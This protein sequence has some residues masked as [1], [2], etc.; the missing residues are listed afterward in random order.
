MNRM[1]KLTALILLICFARVTW[2]NILPPT[3]Q[4]IAVSTTYDR[5]GAIAKLSIWD[6]TSGGYDT[7][8]KSKWGLNFWT[9]NSET[10][11][12]HGMCPTRVAHNGEWNMVIS[13]KFVEQR[14]GASQVIKLSATRRSEWV[15]ADY[16]GSEGG[17]YGDE[18]PMNA[19]GQ[20]ICGSTYT[21]GVAL[22]IHIAPDELKKI[23]VGG[24]WKAR[25]NITLHSNHD[26]TKYNWQADITLNV[27]DN[28]NQAI[29][30]PEFGEA[31]PQIDLNLRP[32]PGTQVN[33]SKLRG[34][35][36][37][38]MCLYDGYGGN[39]SSFVLNFQDTGAA[40]GRDSALFSV[41][42]EGGDAQ[43][44]QDRIDYTLSLRSPTDNTS[45]PVR[46]GEDLTLDN[47]NQAQI[48]QVH[49]PNI[50]QPV[51]CIPAPL[52]LETPE[53]SISSKSAGRY[54]GT[55]RINFTPQL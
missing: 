8:N 17:R 11:P 7:N 12:E 23:P 48:R 14:S 46:R 16:C 43:N 36:N 49:L 10:D 28:S 55:L 50:P 34:I 30:L 32:L 5:S 27:T 29:Y 25:L 3:A 44:I 35:T 47:L 37:L 9:C 45:L 2:A 40:A 53:F 31:Q 20:N 51:I 15:P 13:Q 22:D 21:S 18:K 38:D 19:S 42:R 39:S 54:R 52:K 6:D 26:S 4:D 1:Q 41:Y 24:I 33:H